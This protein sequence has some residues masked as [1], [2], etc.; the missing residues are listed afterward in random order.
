MKVGYLI[1]AVLYIIL[2]LSHASH[3]TENDLLLYGGIGVVYFLMS[4]AIN[5]GLHLG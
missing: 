3:N 1:V 5:T 4:D 2:A